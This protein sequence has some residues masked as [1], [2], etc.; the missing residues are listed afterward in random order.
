MAN[1]IPQ[2]VGKLTNIV[3]N[4]Q[5]NYDK[6]TF[7]PSPNKRIPNDILDVYTQPI[8]FTFID[9]TATAILPFQLRGSKP[10]IPLKGLS[11]LSISEHADAYPVTSLGQKGL[12]GFTRGHALTAGSFGFTIFDRDPFWEMIQAYDQWIHNDITKSISRPHHLPPWDLIINFENERGERAD[13]TLRS[14]VMIDGSQSMGV[15]IVKMTQAY[16]FICKGVTTFVSTTSNS[17]VPTVSPYLEVSDGYKS[18]NLNN[19]GIITGPVDLHELDGLSPN[20]YSTPF[21]TLLQKP[22]GV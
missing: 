10:I 21:P 11:V 2:L 1:V 4:Y 3:S 17:D 7:G 19:T 9:A 13:I 16:S 20:D 15:D 6:L 22:K 5:N 14:I 18:A 12:N 8:T